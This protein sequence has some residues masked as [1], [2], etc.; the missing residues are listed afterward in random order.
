MQI[1]LN[2]VTNVFQQWLQLTSTHL[3]FCF[4]RRQQC[5]R[6]YIVRVLFFVT[7]YRSSVLFYTVLIVYGHYS[8]KIVGKKR[9]TVHHNQQNKQQ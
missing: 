3:I 5:Q 7:C 6:V 2:Y 4:S 9:Y 1:V 8:V